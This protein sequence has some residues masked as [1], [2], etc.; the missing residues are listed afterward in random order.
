MDYCISPGGALRGEFALPG[1]KSISHRAA[2]CA[3]IANG[4]TVIDGFLPAADTLATVNALRR[5]GIVADFPDAGADGEPGTRLVV[6]GGALRTASGALDLGNSGTG[7]R[8]LAGLLAAEPFA[9]ELSGDASLRRRP[10]RRI[11]DPLRRMGAEIS[12]RQGCPPLRIRGGPLRAI[13][14]DMP[15][16]SA[17]LKSCLMLAA[18]RAAGRSEISEPAPSRDHSERMF[19]HFGVELVHRPGHVALSGGQTLRAADLCVPG[20]FSSA[21]FFVVGACIAPHSEICLRGVGINPTRIGALDILRGMGA[22]IVISARRQLAAEPVADLRV[23]AAPLSGVDIP[24]S[25]VAGA[26]DEFPALFVAAAC[27]TGRTRL[28]GAA[29]LRVKE[30]DRLSTM[31]R[32][33]SAMGARAQERDDGIEIVGGPLRGASVDSAGDHRVAMAMSM[34]GLV[35]DGE[36]VVRGCDNVGTSFPGFAQLARRAGLALAVAA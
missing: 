12:D 34:A 1:D 19:E 10:M 6:R 2:I 35:A 25:A 28:R 18:L 22:D 32:N 3:A 33:L 7:I 13:A 29:E 23:R 4:V 26:I 9:S 21:L 5:L 20:D 11:V 15:V 17:Q 14:Y 30:S 16:A 27:A 36:T 24:P 8:L 31:A